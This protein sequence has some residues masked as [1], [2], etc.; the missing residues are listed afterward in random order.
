MS[1]TVLLEVK[2][3][4]GY[5]T[6]NRP[7]ALNALSSQVLADLNEVLDQVEK[8]EEIRVVI[9]TGAGE[10][11][12]VAGADIKEMDLMSPIQAFEYMTFAND[13][14]TRL[15]D[16]RQPTIAVIN[17]YALGGGM[18]LA[19]ST[20]I[21]IG[22]EKTVVGFP[23]VGLGIIPGFA[24]TQRMSR[25]IGTSRAKE[26][27]FTARTV[28]GQEAYDLGILN[29]LVPAEELLSSAEELAAAIMKNAP[30]AVEK[31][32]H[33]IQ[34]GAELPLKN[35]IRLETEAEGLLFS[36]EDKLEGMRAFVEK[37]KAVFNRK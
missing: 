33:V 29:K 3:G 7:E 35:A 23:E 14:F 15:S 36:T 2:N 12:F 26:L 30:L 21:R 4:I 16:L 37:R 5:I 34:V 9:V 1:K 10:K 27:I 19:L 6:I 22:F 18:E 24:G 17:G 20:D 11:A 8:S 32:K 13:T 31:A 25:L 28:K